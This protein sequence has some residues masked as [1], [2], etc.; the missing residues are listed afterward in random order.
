[1]ASERWQFGGG[2]GGGDSSTSS[3]TARPA[4]VVSS[5]SWT[6]DEDFGIL[7]AAAAA[8]DATA[9]AADAT[10]AA[11]AAASTTPLPDVLFVITGRGPQREE[12]LARIR[13]M[14]FK[15]V[16]F[17]SVWLE[18]DDYPRLLGAADLGVCLHTSS[19][20]LDLPMKVVDMF[21]AGLPVCA[22]RFACIGELVEDGATGALFDDA[23]GLSAHLQRLLAGFD[24]GGDGGGGDGSNGELGRMRAAV[25]RVHDGWRW[26]A[27]WRGVAGPVIEAAYSGGAK[28]AAAAAAAVAEEEQQQQQRGRR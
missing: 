5:T 14:R 8:Y 12:Y 7:L 23:A 2:S 11:P 4:L 19:S 24:G 27:N 18:P 16:A 3:A 13:Q 17:A 9:D 28:A 21:G 20:G 22:V 25:A 15:R 6:P 10:K 26:D 1:V